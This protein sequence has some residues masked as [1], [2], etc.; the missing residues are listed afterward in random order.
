MEV[1]LWQKCLIRLEITYLRIKIIYHKTILGLLYF[2]KQTFLWH[3]NLIKF[4]FGER[5]E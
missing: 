1:T 4:I 5:Y 2:W 3:Y